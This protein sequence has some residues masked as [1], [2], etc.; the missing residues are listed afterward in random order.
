MLE[1][2]VYTLSTSLDSGILIFVFAVAM[3][4]VV[5]S[6][7]IRFFVHGTYTP[8]DDAELIAEIT[9]IDKRKNICDYCGMPLKAKRPIVCECCVGVNK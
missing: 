5:V 7:F 2:F 8:V 9:I 6:T 4:L 1:P 3:G